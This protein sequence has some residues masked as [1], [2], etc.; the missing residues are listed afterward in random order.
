MTPEC[1][2]LVRV[3]SSDHRCAKS[4]GH[5]GSASVWVKQSL[6]KMTELDRI[7]AIDFLEK[8]F[9]DRTAK[10]IERMRRK[11]EYRQST[12]SAKLPDVLECFQA[13]YFGRAHVQQNYVR[14]FQPH[15]GGRYQQN[16]HRR[17]IREHFGAFEHC[18]MQRDGEN[19]EAELFR[20]FEQFVRRIIDH[21]L[22]I[23][24]CMD[25][26]INFDPVRVTDL[27]HAHT[28]TRFVSISSKSTST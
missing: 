22:R 9:T 7:E 3:G 14:A 8:T 27:A 1:V 2:Q 25:V 16:S 20:A 24:E 5:F 17:R 4:S 28:H 15:F 6:V 26:Q 12:A 13:C 21:V 10:H 11:G 18:V 23:V 19:A